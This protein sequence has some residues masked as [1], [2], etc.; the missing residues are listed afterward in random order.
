LR[1]AIRSRTMPTRSVA[2]A[3]I[4]AA[5][6]SNPGPVLGG[7][8]APLR[9]P[10]GLSALTPTARRAASANVVGCPFLWCMVRPQ[11]RLHAP[12]SEHQRD[13][14]DRGVNDPPNERGTAAQRAI[15][16][17]SR[18]GSSP[19]RLGTA[20]RG[21]TE[22]RP[23]DALSCSAEVV[24]AL[25]LS[26]LQ[27]NS[28]PSPDVRSFPRRGRTP[29]GL[30]WCKGFLPALDPFPGRTEATDERRQMRV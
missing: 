9:G 12:D 7:V 18:H 4:R 16:G 22:R 25:R 13:T 28:A 6:R 26:R 1:R 30:R 23:F 20:V 15:G 21:G 17:R 8:K 29:A 14:G 11:T 27:Q 19:I 5:D 24:A 2:H 10:S 3:I